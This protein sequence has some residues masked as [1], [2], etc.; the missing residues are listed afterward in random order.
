MAFSFGKFS[1]IEL[2]DPAGKAQARIS[3]EEFPT[4]ESWFKPTHLQGIRK[5]VVSFSR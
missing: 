5:K 1:N 2:K 3:M 4:S